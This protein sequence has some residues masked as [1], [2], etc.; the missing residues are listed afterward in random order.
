M[1]T[2][3]PAHPDAERHFE[4]LPAP[5]FHAHVVAADEKEKILE[6]DKEQV[7]L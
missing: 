2:T 5:G 1:P 4:V 7:R 3:H 6:G